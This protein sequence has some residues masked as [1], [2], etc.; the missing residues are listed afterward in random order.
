VELIHVHI[1]EGMLNHGFSE[2]SAGL[3]HD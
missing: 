2:I 1:G 3:D